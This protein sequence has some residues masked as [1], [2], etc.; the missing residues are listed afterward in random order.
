MKFKTFNEVLAHRTGMT[1]AQCER[2]MKGLFAVVGGALAGGETVKIAG[3]GV[4]EVVAMGV[5]GGVIR[6]PRSR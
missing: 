3:F 4:F 2:F 1:E 6:A 5:G